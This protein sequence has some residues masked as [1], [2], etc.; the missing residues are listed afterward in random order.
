MKIR[1]KNIPQ[2]GAFSHARNHLYKERLWE[3]E[4]KFVTKIDNLG[5]SYDDRCRTDVFAFGPNGLVDGWR[6]EYGGSY[7]AMYS[8]STS[9]QST[10]GNLNMADM[11]E[12]AVVLEI[13]RHW[14]SSWVRMYVNVTH[15]AKLLP[16]RPDDVDIERVKALLRPFKSLKAPYRQEPLHALNA[17]TQELEDLVKRGW[18]K[19]HKGKQIKKL[20]RP[21]W[22]GL[23]HQ[24]YKYFDFGGAKITTEGKNIVEGH[25]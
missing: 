15:K 12:E 13:V 6:G 22:V 25:I 3:V 14:K 18:L 20:E 9:A 23:S 2:I 11:P 4:V 5:I 16:K 17:T 10:A 8:S 19:C 21:V 24:M 7:A 1:T